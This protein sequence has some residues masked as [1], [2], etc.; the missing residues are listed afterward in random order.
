MFRSRQGENVGKD[1]KHKNEIKMWGKLNMVSRR[2]LA[3]VLAGLE[4]DRA[5][6]QRNLDIVLQGR[7][8]EGAKIVA[9]C[10]RG[11]IKRID[12]QMKTVI[13]QWRK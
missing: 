5:S 6:A 3:E 11:M 2:S 9:Y 4:E 7:Q 1:N 12:E 13:K 8:T 10:W